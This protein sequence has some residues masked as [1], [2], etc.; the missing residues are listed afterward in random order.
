MWLQVW[1]VLGPHQETL[2]Y[3]NLTF[4]V[5]APDN[6]NNSTYNLTGMRLVNALAPLGEMPESFQVGIFEPYIHLFLP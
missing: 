4:N 2:V 3:P 6:D 5:A 1:T